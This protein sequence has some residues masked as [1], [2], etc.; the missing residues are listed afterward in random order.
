MKTNP[1]TIPYWSGFETLKVFCMYDLN[2]CV[3]LFDLNLCGTCLQTCRDI[4]QTCG[5]CLQT[6]GTC[7][8][9]CRDTFAN[10]SQHICEPTSKK[11]A[12]KPTIC[13]AGRAIQL[14]V[15][16]YVE[17]KMTNL[18]TRRHIFAKRF[19]VNFCKRE[20]ARK[21]LIFANEYWKSVRKYTYV[22][23]FVVRVCKQFHF[24]DAV[25]HIPR[26]LGTSSF[27]LVLYCTVL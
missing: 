4:L 23:R 12:S 27:L 17:W 18:Q 20:K 24:A 1:T 3:F 6:C 9:T 25:Q 5:T 11:Q 10:M 14:R 19:P 26:F 21:S 22:C 15:C 8:Q 13:R 2:L 7:L 16:K